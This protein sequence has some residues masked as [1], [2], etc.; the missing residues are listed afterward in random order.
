MTDDRRALLTETEYQIL[1]GEKDV[2]SNHY[3]TTVSR[4]RKKI[5]RL[6][7]D[8]AALEEHGGLANELREVVCEDSDSE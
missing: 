4:V 2:G 6:E 3:Y 8:L 7:R 1:T 5:G